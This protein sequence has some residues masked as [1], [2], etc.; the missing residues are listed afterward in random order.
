MTVNRQSPSGTENPARIFIV[1]DHPIIHEGLNS[2]IGKEPDMT[3][4]GGADSVSEARTRLCESRADTAVVDLTL[5]EGSGLELIKDIHA[6]YPNLPILVLSMR[7]EL[8]FAERALQAGARGYVMKESAGASLIG[9][10]KTVLKGEIYLSDNMSRRLL[11]RVAG[12][13][14]AGRS[15]ETDRLTDRELEV[16]RLLGN[17]LATREIAEKLHRSIKTIQSHRENIKHKLGCRNAAEL[18]QRAVRWVEL[19]TK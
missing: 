3:V 9:A 7:D 15:L 13:N 1:D 4:C 6:R 14:A 10:I 12:G 2:L 11:A 19:A 17:G 16:F 8:M 18:V 5:R